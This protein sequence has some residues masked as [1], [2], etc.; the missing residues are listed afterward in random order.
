MSETIR[1]S[2]TPALTLADLVGAAT[3]LSPADIVEGANLL[4]IGPAKVKAV[5]DVESAGRGFASDRRPIILFEPHIFHRRTKGRF[6]DAWPEIS[7]PTWGTHP[8]PGSQ[9]TRYAQLTQ[10]MALDPTA[11][12]M[13]TSWGLF[14]IMGFDFIPAGG[15]IPPA[16][17]GE[18][19]VKAGLYPDVRAFVRDMA[20]NEREQLLAFCRFVAVQ[21]RILK[22]LQLGDWA[23]FARLY[24]GPGYAQHRYDQRLK[25]AFA[26]ERQKAAA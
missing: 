8:Y 14:Q 15:G 10:A 17:P 19:P 1:A 16:N 21:P 6:S 25:V 5:V 4:K 20:V 2:V 23:G 26:R 12:L 9:S 22:A 3:P 24:N 18:P 13:S 11:A 7:Y